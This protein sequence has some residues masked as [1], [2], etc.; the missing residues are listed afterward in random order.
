MTHLHL[1]REPRIGERFVAGRDM[2]I[3]AVTHHGGTNRYTIHARPVFSQFPA[4][5]EREFTGVIR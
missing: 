5:E 3:T 2:V 1:T 4:R